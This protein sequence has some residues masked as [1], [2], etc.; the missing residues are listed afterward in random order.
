MSEDKIKLAIFGVKYYPSRGGTSRVVESLLPHLRD[1]YHTSIYCYAHQEAQDNIPGVEAIQF[2]VPKIKKVGV[3]IFFVKCLWHLMTKGS[4]DLVHI[5]KT[6]A[7]F[8]SPIIRLKYPTIATSHA[9]PYLN[10]KW[11]RIGKLFF[12]LAERVFIFGGARPTAISK[13]Q[14][15]YYEQKYAREVKYIPNF[16]V[17]PKVAPEAELSQFL[18]KFQ[19]SEPYLLFAARR[20][21]PLKGCHHMIRA[22]QAMQYKGQVIVAGDMD[23]MPAY[24]ASLRKQSAGLNLKF[25]GYIESSTLLNALVEQA[26]L[27]VFPSEIEGM[28][29]MLLEVANLKTP[30]V[31]SDIPQNQVI[32][33]SSQVYF[34]ES[35][36]S[37]DLRSRLEEVLAD[38]NYG[39]HRASLALRH[40]QDNYSVD[41]VVDEYKALYKEHIQ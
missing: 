34:F 35:K 23:Q 29:M 6:E 2:S 11:N 30:I 22:L 5:H 32:F 1:E 37:S 14:S 38:P 40:V 15:Q 18:E 39:S 27:F 26:L 9:I 33:D 4:Y 7:A 36:N 24:S 12:R 25:V 28:S 21:I 31:C 3:F 16:V 10:D 41:K 17:K 8:F 20:V 19:V 13:I